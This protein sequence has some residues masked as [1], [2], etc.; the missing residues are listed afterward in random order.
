M[1]TKKIVNVDD[2]S[3]LT[4]EQIAVNYHERGRLLKGEMERLFV[5]A[6][7]DSHVSANTDSL[8]AFMYPKDEVF[9]DMD[10]EQKITL[11]VGIGT[12]MLMLLDRNLPAHSLLARKD[13][14]G[15]VQRAILE[16]AKGLGKPLSKEA[17]DYWCK[18]WTL[19]WN[20]AMDK[21]KNDYNIE[22]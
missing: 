12:W 5:L 21:I 19:T 4:V 15:E 17:L 1:R 11:G 16:L 10:N 3:V 8:A 13:R 9:E 14:I 22:G 2:A 18:V 7:K 20:M 6:D